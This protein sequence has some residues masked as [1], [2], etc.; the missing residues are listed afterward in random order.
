MSPVRLWID[1]D[2][3]D[4]PDDVVALLC[5]ARIPTSSSSGVS[6]VPDL[7]IVRPDLAAELV[8]APVHG[9]GDVGALAEAFVDAAPDALL[10]IGPLGQRRRPRRC[11]HRSAR[12]DRHGRRR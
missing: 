6:I 8:A 3:G 5:A 11:R 12:N 9:G 10:A 1:T 4:D 7:P 2:V